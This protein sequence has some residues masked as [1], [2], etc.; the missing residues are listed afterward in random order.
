[1][2][3]LCDNLVGIYKTYNT[4]KTI[5][6]N[7]KLY[8]NAGQTN[9]EDNAAQ[10]A[11]GKDGQQIASSQA[12]DERNQISIHGKFMVL[13]FSTSISNINLD[14]RKQRPNGRGASLIISSNFQ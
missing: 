3:E 10:S 2:F 4:T 13:F 9:T 8:D 11:E 12:D 7:P 1:M 14:F 6:I 5:T